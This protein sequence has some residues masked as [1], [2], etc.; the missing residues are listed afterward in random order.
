[1][2]VQDGNRQ[3][4]QFAMEFGRGRAMRTVAD[5]PVAIAPVLGATALE[6]SGYPQLTAKSDP[7]QPELE[8]L[9]GAPQRRRPSALWLPDPILG[10]A[11]PGRGTAVEILLHPE[12]R[13]LRPGVRAGLA[14]LGTERGRNLPNLQLELAVETVEQVPTACA[15][16]VPSPEACAAEREVIPSVA[17]WRACEIRAAAVPDVRLDAALAE[18][19]GIAAPVTETVPGLAAIAAEREVVPA[20]AAVF[21][22][23]R[24]VRLP[25]LRVA[26]APTA[27]EPVAGFRT[28]QLAGAEILPAVAAERTLHSSGTRLPELCIEATGEAL[29][30]I[31]ELCVEFMAVPPVQAAEREVNPAMAAQFVESQA[32]RLPLLHIPIAATGADRPSNF[33]D[34]HPAF[35]NGA[36]PIVADATAYCNGVTRLPR[37]AVPFE[38]L[39]AAV[40][41]VPELCRQPMPGAP[42]DAVEREVIAAMAQFAKFGCLRMPEMDLPVEAE[43][44][45][46]IPEPCE[47]P[48]TPAAAYPA[49]RMLIAATAEALSM[50]TLRMPELT[51]A[52]EAEPVERIPE[53]C[54]VPMMTLAAFPAERMVIAATAEAIT[55]VALVRTPGWQFQTATHVPAT[56]HWRHADAPQAVVV[57]VDPQ[58]RNAPMSP[59]RYPSMA[60]LEP[61]ADSIAKSKPSRAAGPILSARGPLA[62]YPAESMPLV[63][64]FVAMAVPFQRQL[65]LPELKLSQTSELGSSIY[66]PQIAPPAAAQQVPAAASP[67]KGERAIPMAGFIPLDFYCETGAGQPVARLDWALGNAPLAIPNPS[68]RATGYQKEETQAP[69]PVKAPTPAGRVLRMP[70]TARMGVAAKI[71]ACIMAVTSLWLAGRMFTGMRSESLNSRNQDVAQATDSGVTALTA[72]QASSQH[73]SS[74]PLASVRGAI[75]RRAAVQVTDNFAY[76]MKAWGADETGWVKGWSR[77]PAGYVRP[78][79]MALFQPSMKYKDYRLEFFGLIENKSMGWMV[80]AKDDQNYYAMKFTTLE[81]GLRPIIAVVHYPVVGGQMGHKVDTPLNVMV[82]N[83]RPYHVAVEV[84][85]NRVRTS[86]EGQEIDSWTDDA[87]M[88]S[89]GVG[90]FTD[91]GARARLY[92]MKVFKNDDLLGRICAALNGDAADTAEV[93][94]PGIPDGPHGPAAPER[95]DAALAVAFGVSYSRRGKSSNRWRQRSW[96]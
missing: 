75:A 84:H 32:V 60:E 39:T 26:I 5:W 61:V 71:A 12:E 85:G 87:L 24:S 73:R 13:P 80:R 86:I 33:R 82:H 66:E 83:N 81:S 8:W 9:N 4:T 67:E 22:E 55:P 45:E 47:V 6:T 88:A 2:P 30:Q 31:P 96:S 68:L 63:S 42:A 43:P 3:F 58:F 41:Q 36:V 78:G 95:S 44:V 16:A 14:W 77:D 52:V 10:P 11:A 56:H 25:Q 50:G 79:E 54:A 29:E 53:P 64:G 20:V 21:L 18:E 93:W 19:Q 49:E 94:G 38:S 90:F 23:T 89:G 65:M 72:A 46:Q 92:W 27:I 74:G 17:D 15:E 40:E 62:A 37:I 51:L 7:G 59:L 57:Q 70:V 69:K 1:M 34:V 48:M 35:S 91:A 76:G 28:P